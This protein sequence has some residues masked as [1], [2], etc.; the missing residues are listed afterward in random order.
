MLCGA[1]APYTAPL[2]KGSWRP[3]R[4]R[5]CHPKTAGERGFPAEGGGCPPRAESDSAHGAG[6]PPQAGT[7]SSAQSAAKLFCAPKGRAFF[8][9]KGKCSQPPILFLPQKENGPLERSKRERARGSEAIMLDRKMKRPLDPQQSLRKIPPPKRR[10]L[11][12]NMVPFPAALCAAGTPM[13]WTLVAPFL[14]LPPSC[15]ALAALANRAR[16]AMRCRTAFPQKCRD[17][18]GVGGAFLLQEGQKAS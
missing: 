1:A 18:G 2:C 6:C 14:E 13:G 9:P 15:A 4:L 11:R 7:G 17:C 16:P 12:G 5:D 10:G 3:C 8:F